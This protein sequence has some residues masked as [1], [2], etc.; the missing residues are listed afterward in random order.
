MID[1]K[2]TVTGDK[3]VVKRLN[4]WKGRLRSV[5]NAGLMI[6]ARRL[7]TLIVTGIRN[8]APGGQAFK[9]LAETTKDMK[10]SSKALIDRGDLIRSIGVSTVHYG[11]AVFVGV[12]RNARGRDGTDL[13]NLAEIHEFGTSPYLIPV[14]DKLRRFWFAMVAKGVFAAP[15]K[16]S[17]TTLRHPGVPAR[18]FLQPAYDVW[19]RDASAR[20]GRYVTNTMKLTKFYARTGG[21]R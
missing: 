11:Q 7:R 3:D 19:A 21:K 1:I 20:F 13:A 12:N 16:P 5:V 18:P 15:L 4:S 14:T 17:T 10:G 8:Q 2:L 9:P 6:E